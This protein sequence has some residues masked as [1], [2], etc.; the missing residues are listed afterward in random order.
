MIQDVHKRRRTFGLPGV[1]LLAILMGLSLSISCF[2]GCA[3]HGGIFGVDCLADVPAGSVPEYAGSKLCRWQLAQIGQ[4][5]IDRTALYRADFVGQSVTLSPAAME[6]I[7]HEVQS[8]RAAN[9]VW[10][11]EPSGIAS[12]DAQ[13]VTSVAQVLGEYKV[14]SPMIFVAS[15]PAIGLPGNVAEGVA[16]RTGVSSRSNR[17]SQSSSG[18]FGRFGF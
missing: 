10:L 9:Q 8:G 7:A 16:G 3:S 17:R 2:S 6:K 5:D 15:P 12:L 13:R 18:F 14:F 4:A 11:V 1:Q